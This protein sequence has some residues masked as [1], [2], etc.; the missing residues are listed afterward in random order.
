VGPA[1]DIRRS[2]DGAVESYDRVRP[3]Y[4]AALF[5]ALFALLPS[6]PEVVE[7]GPG[8]G[9]ATRDLLARGA[10]VHAVEIGPAMADALRANLPS[11][12]LRITVGDVEEVALAPASADALVAA[13]SYH[14]VSP[15]AQTDL[16]VRVLRPGGTVA[17]VDTIQVDGPEDAGFFAAARPVYERHGQGHRGP[18]APRRGDVDPPVRAVLDADHRFSAVAVRRFDQDQTYTA[19]AYRRLMLSYSGTQMMEAAERAALLD[20]VEA[21]VHRD[22]GGHVTRPLVMTLTTATFDPA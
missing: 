21:L 8:T 18:P 5:D 16:P 20:A 4:P 14:W 13:T 15:S 22:F 19:A 9:Q 7:V 11:D 3:T 17:I 12:R 10:T 1:D 2:F 6:A